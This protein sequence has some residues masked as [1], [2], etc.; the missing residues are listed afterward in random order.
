[1][2][3][4]RNGLRRQVTETKEGPLELGRKREARKTCLGQV[5][6]ERQNVS[7]TSPSDAISNSRAL[8]EEL[9]FW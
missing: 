1:M 8:K 6:R 4:Q 5:G 2:N 7:T 3:C 9:T